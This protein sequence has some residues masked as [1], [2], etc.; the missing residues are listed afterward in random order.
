MAA[1]R[2]GAGL[3]IGLCL[4]ALTASSAIARPGAVP[5]RQQLST[6]Y[7]VMRAINGT[8]TR[9]KSRDCWSTTDVFTVAEVHADAGTP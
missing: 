7:K 5:H 8:I 4:A 2:I 6:V 1:T 9:S 3:T